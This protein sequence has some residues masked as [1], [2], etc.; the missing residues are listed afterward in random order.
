MNDHLLINTKEQKTPEEI[1]Q[2]FFEECKNMQVQEALNL[3][4]RIF[5]NTFFTVANALKLQPKQVETQ[6]RHLVKDMKQNVQTVIG[7][8]KEL[9]KKKLTIDTSQQPEGEDEPDEE[10]IDGDNET[11]VETQPDNS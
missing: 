11:P 9:Q 5:I 8:G 10:E 3:S 4:M 6:F 2:Q 1:E 7:L